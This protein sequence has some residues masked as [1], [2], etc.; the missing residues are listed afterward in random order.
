[1]SDKKADAERRLDEA[2][3]ALAEQKAKRDEAARNAGVKREGAFPG[4]SIAWRG[5][6]RADGPVDPTLARQ[7]M[8]KRFLAQN[9]SS[10]K[11]TVHGALRHLDGDATEMLQCPTCVGRGVLEPT[12]G[13]GAGSV[14][15]CPTCQGRK[16][17][18][19]GV[20]QETVRVK[21]PTCGGSGQTNSGNENGSPTIC[22]TCRGHGYIVKPP[23]GSK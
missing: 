16:A 6:Q 21:C 4:K 10:A 20:R 11:Y 15:T 17:I 3:A 14:T 7:A 18:P 8:V 1:M 5:T 23:G 13:I 19:S 12:G 9:L 22:D 2:R